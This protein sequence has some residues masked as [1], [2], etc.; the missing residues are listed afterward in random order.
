MTEF[1]DV[2]IIGVISDTHNL[3]RPEA[4]QALKNSDLIIHAGDIGEQSIV[5]KLEKIAPVIAVRG[6]V[7]RAKWC[8]SLPEKL[9]IKVGEVEIYIIHNLKELE[10]KDLTDQVKIIISGHSHKPLHETKRGVTYLNP[11]SA[12]RRR[13]KLPISLAKIT[14]EEEEIRAEILELSV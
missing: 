9:K 4:V 12:G 6:N 10:T 11:G 7:D 14:I 2:K 8:E 1:R 5:D 3:L 13:F